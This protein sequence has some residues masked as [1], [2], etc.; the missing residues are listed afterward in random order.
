MNKQLKYILILLGIFISINGGVVVAKENIRINQQQENELIISGDIEQVEQLYQQGKLKQAI[1]ILTQR[2]NNYQKQGNSLKQAYALRNISLVYLKQQNWQAT[3]ANINQA[4]E[5]TNTI[6]D[7]KKRSQLLNLCLEI[8]GQLQLA[9]DKPEIALKT[10]QKSSKL[11][12]QRG[13]IRQYIKSEIKQVQALQEMG[14][15][16][17]AIAILTQ[18]EPQ[19]DKAPS[20]L[21]TAKAW[22]TIGDLLRKVGKFSEAQSALKKGLIIVNKREN[23]TA[24]ADFLIS[25]GNL[26]KAQQDFN[27]AINFY[28]EGAKI[29][30]DK[31][32]QLQAYLPQLNIL[33]TQKSLNWSSRLIHSQIIPLINDLPPSKN[34]VNHRI[35]LAR[36]LIQINNSEDNQLILEQL[37]KANREA[38][39]ID[40]RRGETN[41]LGNLGK[42]YQ[43]SQQLSQARQLTEK[44]LFIAQQINAPDIAY[45]WQWQLGQI[46]SGQNDRKSAITSYSQA[47]YTLNT[48]RSDLVAVNSDL[49]FNFRENVEPVYRELV[50]ILLQEEATVTEIG[51]ARDVIEQLQL[52]ELDNFFQSACIDANPVLIDQVTEQQDPTAAVIY[53][54]ALANRFEI[55]LKLPQEQ[56][57]HYSIAIDNLPKVERILERLNQSL[58]QRNSQETLS[59]SQ[60]AYDWLIRPI[61]NDLAQSEVKTLV[62]VLDNPFRNVPMAVLHDGQ[63][64]LVEK[65]G[66]ALSPGLQLIEPR[67][68]AQ[69]ELNLL[70]AGLTQ[71]REGFSPLKYVVNEL[72]TIQSEVSNN[73]KLLDQN[74][75]TTAF[76]DLVKELP[77]SVVHIATHGQFSSRAENTFILTWDD[78]IN[79]NQL[80]RLLRSRVPQTEE[81]LELLVLSACETLTGDKRATLGLAGMAVRAGARSTLATLWRVNDEA[82]ALLMGQFYKELANQNTSVTKAEA[83]RQAQLTLLKSSRFNRPYFWSSYVL[84]G[85]WL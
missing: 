50:D 36:N 51:Q 85:N 55:I 45:Q 38:K 19:L 15:Y 68:I 70:V 29:T 9:I 5:L 35:N 84:V 83:L 64:Y 28:Q 80:H 24:K 16:G 46:M 10:W 34:L 8:K 74:F 77:F 40:Y 27:Q 30:E 39:Q 17:Q 71:S 57:K 58:T 73:E 72:N 3:E 23:V 11:A 2:I 60:Q 49:E 69:Q 32:L 61:A 63:Q 47:V 65:Y 26:A 44:A 6:N 14:M 48:L 59:L 66:V 43:K 12:Y 52:A 4:L 42:L 53:T 82:S 18:I 67:S 33:V 79:V 78:Q 54:I 1:A 81:A 7:Q 56:L 41:A 13:D 37:I 76:Q 62:F 21:V 20:D 75:T 22:Q 31:S 25:L